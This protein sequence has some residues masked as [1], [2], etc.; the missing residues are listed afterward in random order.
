MFVIS[1]DSGALGGEGDDEG[2]EDDEREEVDG[3]PGIC[4][5]FE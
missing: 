5:T 1:V 3:D 4:R 2:S